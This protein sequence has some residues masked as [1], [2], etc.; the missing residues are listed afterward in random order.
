MHQNKPFG[1]A[2]YINEQVQPVGTRMKIKSIEREYEDGR[3]DI[4][5]EALDLYKM[6]TY[7]HPMENKLYAGAETTP[8]PYDK[9]GDVGL[10]GEIRDKMSIIFDSLQID[11]RLPAPELLLT[12][13]IAH[14]IGWDLQEEYHLLCMKKEYDRQIQ[15]LRQISSLLPKIKTAEQV[16]SKALLNGEFRSYRSPTDF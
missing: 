3:M 1:L 14:S 8:Y 13:H 15:V 4:K 7:V 12:Y 6:E 2:P 16:K 10:A 9:E 5:T 11:K